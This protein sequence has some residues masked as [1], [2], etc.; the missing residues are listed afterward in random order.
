[1]FHCISSRLNPEDDFQLNY[2]ERTKREHKE[3][4][5]HQRQICFSFFIDF[6]ASSCFR[7]NPQTRITFSQNE[8]NAKA[9]L[10]AVIKWIN[11]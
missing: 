3:E 8:T 9:L 4:A 1:M 5:N 10:E 7:L 6:N 11:Y 2:F